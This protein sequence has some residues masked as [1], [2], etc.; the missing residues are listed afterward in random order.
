MERSPVPTW[1][2]SG[3]TPKQRAF[4]EALM[5][6]RD[7]AQEHKDRLKQKLDNNQ[8]DVSQ[9]SKTIEWLLKQPKLPGKSGSYDQRPLYDLHPGRYAIEAESGELRFYH[10]WEK[11]TEDN[12]IHRLYVLHGP[13]SSPLPMPAQNAIARKI[14]D[15]GML[16]CAIRYGREIGACSNC[17]RR[18]TNR[19]SRYLGIGPVCGQRLH[20]G[21]KDTVK[22]AR[23]QLIEQGYDPEEEV[24]DG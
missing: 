20:E 11:K 17:G 2:N 24:G 4:I 12:I 1:A 15:A 9:A 6:E 13:D 7:F 19:I 18:L 8:L 10:L 16:E 3:P 14:L 22:Y 21:F 5:E 23:K